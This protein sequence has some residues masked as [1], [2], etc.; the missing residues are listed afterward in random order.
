MF[1]HIT[2]T[3]G[4]LLAQPPAGGKNPF[5]GI[6]PDFSVFGVEFTQ[7]WQKLLAG[8]W[9]LAFVVAAFGAVRAVLE[10]QHAKKGG[11]QASVHEHTESAKRSG[12][13]VLGLAALGIIFG[14]VVALF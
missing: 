4:D 13:A 6:T 8:L 11:Y 2:T 12:Y 9:G 1:V 7:G 5:D 3:L 10:L 14:A